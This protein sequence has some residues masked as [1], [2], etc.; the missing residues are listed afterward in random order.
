MTRINLVPPSG[1][2]PAGPAGVKCPKLS[3]LRDVPEICFGDI[4][5]VDRHQ[6]AQEAPCTQ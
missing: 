6:A 2:V 1:R 4:Q 3:G 5:G